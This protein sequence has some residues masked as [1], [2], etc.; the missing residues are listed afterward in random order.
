MSTLA[1]DNRKPRRRNLC[2]RAGVVLDRAGMR[3]R[4]A[5][6][7]RPHDG[8]MACLRPAPVSGAD[9]Q[10]G[11]TP[12]NERVK[13]VCDGEPLVGCYAAVAC[14]AHGWARYVDSNGEHQTKHGRVELV[15]GDGYQGL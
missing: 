12:G 3:H 6:P 13:V 9:W 10:G 15:A 8:S 4:D 1:L 2:A 14:G 5:L 7:H 11:V